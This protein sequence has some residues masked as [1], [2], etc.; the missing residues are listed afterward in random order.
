LNISE[1]AKDIGKFGGWQQTPIEQSC[2]RTKQLPW[3]IC[4][5]P[6]NQPQIVQ[7]FLVRKQNK[8]RGGFEISQ[9]FCKNF[10]I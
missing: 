6:L 5:G 8:W 10:Q 4:S 3:A 7:S 2:A 1:I 9:K